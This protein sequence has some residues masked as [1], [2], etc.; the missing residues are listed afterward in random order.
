VRAVLDLEGLTVAFRHGSDE[1][2]VVSKVAFQLHGGRILG[3]AGESGSG[4]STAALT[5]IGFPIAHSVRLGGVS[6]LDEIDLLKAP[7]SALR[8]LWGRR[9]AYVAQDASQALSPLMKVGTQLEEPLRLHL[10]LRGHELE[11]RA[12]E[13]LKSVGIPDPALA[14]RRY[15]HQFSGGQQQRIALAIAMACEPRVLIL[16]E[17]TTGLDVTTQAQIM[18]LIHTLV[19]GTQTAALMISH[20]LALL[21]TI[22]DEIAI[23]YAGEIVEHGRAS[24]IY[25]SPRHPYSA[26]LIDSV[27]RIDEEGLVVGIPG[28]PPRRASG[29]N[30]AF[31]D[32]CRF[33][34]DRCATIH[35]ALELV[36]P[37]REV[38]CI[39]AAELGPIE[40]LRVAS[41]AMHSLQNE[42]ELLTVRDLTC[43][44]GGRSAPVVVE[45]VSFGVGRGE[46][47]AL[48]GESGSGKSTVLRAIAGLHPPDSGTIEFSHERLAV[49]AVHRSRAT[50]KRIQIVFQ[51]PHSSLNPRHRVGDAIL[52][53]L[54]LFRSDLD[55]AGRRRRLMQLLADVRLDADI[56]DRYPHQLS[57]GQ[58]QRVALARAFAADPELILCDEVVSALD[59]SVQA[60]ILELLVN[61]AGV[62]HTALLFVTHD[63]AVVHSIADRVF[64]MRL[65]RIVESGTAR[66][67]FTAPTDGYT[68]A[69]LAA[70]PRPLSAGIA[71]G[72]AR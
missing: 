1:A 70:V 34:I 68:R 13:L 22:C 3:I 28:M 14:R 37:G 42:E 32:R 72:E 62:K 18:A 53:P 52:R 39:R 33:A 23:M 61:L 48:V 69:L 46:T 21:A 4:K 29:D 38:R 10:G 30:C 44:Y 71:L 6:R 26:A 63:L 64:V 25:S 65:G 41:A 57:G 15:P 56:A 11:Q 20:D 45:H 54:Q 49:R 27:P 55:R 36:S 17:P 51:D 43:S 16:D 5:S 8:K 7:A 47:V 24:E 60:S 67:I 19:D 66:D 58:K 31:V 40:S 35:P 9:L 2:V 12:T 50:R 59:V